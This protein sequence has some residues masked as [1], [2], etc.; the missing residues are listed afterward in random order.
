MDLDTLS[1]RGF[2]IDGQPL[3]PMTSYDAASQ[4]RRLKGW[5]PGSAGPTRAVVSQLSTVRARSRDAARNNG[6][7]ANAIG[8]WVSNEVG[9]GI[10]PRSKSPDKAFAE[11]S[12]KLW[13]EFTAEADYD[14]VLDVYGLMA[15]AVRGRKEAGEMFVRIRHLELGSGTAVPVQFQLIESEQVP[16]THHEQRPETEI[17]AGVEFNKNTG[18]RTQY[19]MYRRH[20][21]DMAQASMELI[22][23]PAAE[24]IHH[25][26]PLRAGQVRGM[27][28]TV[29]A[30]VKARDF[31]E[32]DDAELVRKKTRANYTGV[33]KRDAFEES[34][35]QYD[36]FTGEPIDNSTG[37]PVVGMEPGT[38][39]ALL[40]GED[41]T[42][43]D[44]DQ[45]GGYGD[46]M[47]QQLMGIAASFGMPYELV[48]GDMGKVNDRILRAILNE[49]RRR[50]EQ[51]QWLY[52]IPQLCQRM[53]EAVID[54]GVL[55]GR[56]KVSDYATNRKAHVAT[57]WRPHAWRYL[58]PVQDAQGELML[59]KG[60]LSSRAAAA[61][62]RG[63]DVE[64]ID[65]QNRIDTE[66][67]ASKGLRYSHDP[68]QEEAE[69]PAPSE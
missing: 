69:E 24:V 67:A 8:N 11:A 23:V 52:T 62:E 63:Y 42:L 61:A 39:P 13:D 40:P 22:P 14:G 2:I 32:Y 66:R 3:T 68:V 59:I 29:Q 48:S 1:S 30:L 57:D 64:D 60:G 51:Y 33:I 12:N 45:G 54:A 9:A 56:L 5:A 21:S 47:R 27:A 15:L 16:H 55:S 4:G 31:D 41:I 58:H 35:Y 25:F 20:P 36:P 6:W 50:I 53:W 46:F 44:G 19:W 7:I 34:D 17:I 65:E 49:Y 28:E 10:K 43:F 18:K 26:A 38:F 37:S